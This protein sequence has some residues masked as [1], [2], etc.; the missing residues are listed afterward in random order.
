MAKQRPSP[1]RIRELIDYDPDTGVFRW[2]ISRAAMKIG[3][4]AGGIGAAGYWMIGIDLCR[5]YGHVVAWAHVTGS[6]PSTFLDH[7]DTN[8]LNN[9]WDN[10]RP[11]SNQENTWNASLKASN[12]SGYKGVSWNSKIHKWCAH[13]RIKG[14]STYLGSFTDPAEAGAAYTEAAKNHFGEFARAK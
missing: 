13:I 7:R 10:I 6:Y 8:R 11:A 9:R 14:K 12:K 5:L 3:D 4:I 2:K 1:E